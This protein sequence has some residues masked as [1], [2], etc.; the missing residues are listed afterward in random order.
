ML[1]AMLALGTA[2]TTLPQVDASSDPAP[3]PPGAAWTA[4]QEGRYSSYIATAVSDTLV[5]KSTPGGEALEQLTSETPIVVALTERPGS[6]QHLKVVVP[7]R[8]NGRVGWVHRDDVTVTWTNYRIRVDLDDRSVTLF[9][10]DEVVLQASAAIGTEANPTPEGATFVTATLVN[11]DAGGLYGPYAL[12][13]AVWSETL[14]EY[15][16]GDGQVGLHGTHRP[17]LL[18]Q[19]VSHGC[20]RVHNDVI[21]EIAGRVP[22]GTPV[23]IVGQAS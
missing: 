9:D 8:P 14:T 22:L 2:C 11:P 5:V 21:R 7:G 4:P 16:G 18:G 6:A 20:V 23:D 15:A 17:D 12:G 19:R 1:V 13:L 3:S 10:R